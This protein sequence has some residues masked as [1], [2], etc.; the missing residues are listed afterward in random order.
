MCY[1]QI[2]VLY[3][4]NVD[5]GMKRV[6][7][8][9]SALWQGRVSTQWQ[10]FQGVM[11]GLGYILATLNRQWGD[12]PSCQTTICKRHNKTAIQEPNPIV[13]VEA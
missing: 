10:F 6:C 13:V 12:G 3:L 11:T 7:F 5:D 4:G 2:F 8:T 9:N 1:C